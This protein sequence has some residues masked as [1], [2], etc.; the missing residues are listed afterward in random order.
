VGQ[1]WRASERDL[2]RT[3]AV[4]ILKPE[5]LGDQQFEEIFRAEGQAL[6]SVDHR[7]IEA[8]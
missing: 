8:D 6:A 3:V 5:L 4:K 7:E 2:N 1:V